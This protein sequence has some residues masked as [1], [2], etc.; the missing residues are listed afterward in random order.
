MIDSEI[1][2]S[3]YVTDVVGVEAWQLV[4]SFFQK[5]SILAGPAFEI[6]NT[7]CPSRKCSLAFSLMGNMLPSVSTTR[8]GS[9]D[10][11]KSY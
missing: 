7:C 3:S 8:R 2:H 6:A 10:R 9:E 4:R 11:L 5:L 1:Y